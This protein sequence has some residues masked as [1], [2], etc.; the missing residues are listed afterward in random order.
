MAVCA[1]SVLIQLHSSSF[2]RWRFKQNRVGSSQ[3][4]WSTEQ[5]P[6]ARPA[7]RSLQLQIGRVGFLSLSP[8]NSPCTQRRVLHEQQRAIDRATYV[9]SARVAG[10]RAC[11]G[12]ACEP[13][14]AQPSGS[15]FPGARDGPVQPEPHYS[16]A[17]ASTPAQ[18]TS[19]RALLCC[20]LPRAADS[21]RAEAASAPHQRA[22]RPRAAAQ[23]VGVGRG[24]RCGAHGG[25]C[26]GHEPGGSVPNASA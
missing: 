25:G 22:Q 18:S 4:D 24:V 9:D 10:S 5:H 12:F 6:S 19:S 17:C 2:L 3:I 16:A 15:P 20:R 1:L 11:G 14:C 8:P 23:R 21:S 7:A 26:S 13:A